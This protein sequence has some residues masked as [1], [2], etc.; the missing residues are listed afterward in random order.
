MPPEELGT[1]QRDTATEE[2]N[3]VT[4]ANEAP[5][6]LEAILAGSP[7]LPGH[8]KDSLVKLSKEEFEALFSLLEKARGVQKNAQV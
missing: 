2:K 7:N 6:S 8:L 5:E 3:G 1:K 4:A